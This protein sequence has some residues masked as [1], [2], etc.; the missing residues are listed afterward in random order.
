MSR[1]REQSG[2]GCDAR[3]ARREAALTPLEDRDTFHGRFA[4][5][6]SPV[7]RT[8]V[9]S[10]RRPPAVG[11]TTGPPPPHTQSVSPPGSH[12]LNCTRQARF[13]FF[14]SVVLAGLT[15]SA[16]EIKALDSAEAVATAK[17]GLPRALPFL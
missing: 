16:T 8:A 10:G 9:V 2:T 4:G 6:R 11:Q 17:M 7:V 12:T 15:L 13:L 1:R 3:R 14:V 5:R